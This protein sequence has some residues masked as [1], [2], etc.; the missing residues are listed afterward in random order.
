MEAIKSNFGDSLYQL[1]PEDQ[2]TS[3]LLDC[4]ACLK[5]DQHNFDAILAMQEGSTPLPVSEFDAALK[6]HLKKRNSM[7]DNLET[8]FANLT[9]EMKLIESSEKSSSTG[10]MEDRCSARTLCKEKLKIDESLPHIISYLL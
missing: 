5:E 7:L 2:K 4:I 8:A 1:K 10:E 9:E 6:E 3:P